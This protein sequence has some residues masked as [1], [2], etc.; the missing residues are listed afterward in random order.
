MSPSTYAPP[1]RSK[2]PPRAK[3]G[4]IMFIATFALVAVAGVHAEAPAANSPTGRGDNYYAAGN[5]IEITTPMTADVIVAG[6]QIDIGQPVAGDI[7]AA[8][9]RVAVTGRAEDDVRIAAGEVTVDAP[10]VGDLTLAGGDV[11]IGSHARV[12]GRAWLT[13]S[14]IRVDGLFEREV[15]IAGATVEISGEIRKPLR[16]VAEKFQILPSARILGPLT[17]KGS[18][19][20][21]IAEGAVVNGPIT[22]DRIP[23]R[24]ARRA[25][26]FPA[27]STLLF[28][29]HVFLA[30]L[31]V[32]I[33]LPRVETSVVEML[34]RQPGRSLLA[35]FVV[36]VTTPVGALLLAISVLGLPIGLALGALYAMALFGGVLVTAFFVGDAEARLFKTGPIITRGQ[37]ALLLLA[38]VLTL[39]LL[40]SLL[41][42]LVVFASLLFGLGALVL[43]AH[44]AYS[45]VS[46]PASA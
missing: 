43:T 34:R 42:G 20:A 4:A 11:T 16:V 10:V 23:E 5:R 40:R 27:V 30:G 45:H 14:T 46:L 17:Y 29:L 36:L 37:H 19:E 3:S 28:A 18:T 39:A 33:F 9:W 38:G 1:V 12:S 44:H 13:G 6:R 15:Q 25:R 2:V 24:E 31:L 32:V 21:R 8:G 26:A 22:Y 7:L 41:G 35:G